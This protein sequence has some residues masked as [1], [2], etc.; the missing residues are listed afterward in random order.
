MNGMPVPDQSEDQQKKGDQQQTG[1]FGGI[2]R[3]PRMLVRRI[4]SRI[5]LEHDGIV[6]PR[7]GLGSQVLGLRSWVLGPAIPAP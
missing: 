5:R 4:F 3:M 2:H 1:G 6:A 7:M